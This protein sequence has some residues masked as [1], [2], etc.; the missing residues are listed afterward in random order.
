MRPSSVVA[1]ALLIIAVA[2]WAQTAPPAP[3]PACTAPEHRQFDFW[4]GEWDVYSTGTDQLVGRNL[5]EKL[6]DGCTIR[7]SWT[8][9][10]GP[11]GSSF[12]TWRPDEKVWRQTWVDGGNSHADFKGGLKDGAMVIAGRWQG[13]NGPGTDGYVRITY[14]R[15]PDGSLRQVGVISQD[16]GRTFQPSFDLTYR[17]SHSAGS[18]PAH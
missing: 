1:P 10:R 12:N 16:E 2:S 9:V 6:Y 17:R 3:A 14:S 4:L 18:Q 13:V 15:Q 5:I 11:G 8:P 7:E